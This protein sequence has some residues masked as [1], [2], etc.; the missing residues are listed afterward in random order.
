MMGL[1]RRSL[2]TGLAAGGLAL[3]GPLRAEEREQVVEAARK[4]GQLAFAT[5]ISLPT[6]ANSS[7]NFSRSPR[8][9][10]ASCERSWVPRQAC[11]RCSRAAK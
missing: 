9:S 10:N 5:S 11:A 2:L 1:S 7:F 6:A 8:S 3:A 4:E